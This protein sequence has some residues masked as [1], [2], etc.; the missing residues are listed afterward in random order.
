MGGGWNGDA[1][2]LLLVA[3]GAWSVLYCQ[4]QLQRIWSPKSWWCV[5]W[6]VVMVAVAIG[7]DHRRCHWLAKKGGSGG[8][9]GP[10]I[11]N[12]Y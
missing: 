2:V 5:W 8:W 7:T 4:Q 11:S 1:M 9:L 12:G 3:D 10:P 6:V